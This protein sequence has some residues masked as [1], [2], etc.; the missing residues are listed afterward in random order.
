MR[1]TALALL[2]SMATAPGWAACYTLYDGANRLV[3]QSGTAPIDLNRSIADEVQRRFPGHH[4]V[5]ELEVACAERGA[6]PGSRQDLAY[7]GRARRP[8]DAPML[9]SAQ[10]LRDADGASDPFE[11][12]LDE[13]PPTAGPAPLSNP[14]GYT[15]AVKPRTT[16][17]PAKPARRA[18]QN[19]PAGPS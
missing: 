11:R 7:D 12:L 9:R 10:A 19:G 8:A 5:M 18:K 2:A 15:R 17:A 4:F 13:A 1:R 3:Y 14:W 16:P 6:L